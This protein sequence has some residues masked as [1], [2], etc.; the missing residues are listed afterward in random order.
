MIQTW[1]SVP[2]H[3]YNIADDAVVSGAPGVSIVK[4]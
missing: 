1:S 4:R 3:N 2:V